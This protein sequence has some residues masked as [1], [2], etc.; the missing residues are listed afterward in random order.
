ML[1]DNNRLNI[2]KSDPTLCLAQFDPISKEKM[3]IYYK[4]LKESWLTG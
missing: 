2:N 1:E 4:E 3:D